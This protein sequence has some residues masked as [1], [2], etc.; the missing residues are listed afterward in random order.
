ML[1]PRKLPAF[2]NYAEGKVPLEKG[3]FAIDVAAKSVVL[4]TVADAKPIDIGT[5]LVYLME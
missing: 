3:V 2:G 5:S 4:T 1:G